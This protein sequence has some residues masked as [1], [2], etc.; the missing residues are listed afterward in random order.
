MQVWLR[1]KISRTQRS[2]KRGLPTGLKWRRHLRL[3]QALRANY[4]VSFVK[5]CRERCRKWINRV[6]DADWLASD[7]DDP[8]SN[9]KPGDKRKGVFDGSPGQIASS[10]RQKL[11]PAFKSLSTENEL[12]ALEEIDGKRKLDNTATPERQ[13]QTV[14][15]SAFSDTDNDQEDTIPRNASIP[16]L[17]EAKDS[18]GRGQVEETTGLPSDQVEPAPIERTAS[19][20]R[21][22]TFMHEIGMDPLDPEQATKIVPLPH[23][24]EARILTGYHHRSTCHKWTKDTYTLHNIGVP[25]RSQGT[26]APPSTREPVPYLKTGRHGLGGDFA[27][28]PDRATGKGHNYDPVDQKKYEEYMEFRALFHGKYPEY[29]KLDTGVSVDAKML[30]AWRRNEVWYQ[31]FRQKYTG[32]LGTQWVCGCQKILD[33][34]EGEGES[35]AE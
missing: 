10:K 20:G 24:N 18:P 9:S 25:I 16:T 14:E 21:L 26:F 15:A 12:L 7:F 17:A 19:S 28:D 22:L 13:Q 31:G 11:H 30:E 27:E 33:E 29:P 34:D 23:C 3:A 5:L 4:N 32:M 2:Q 6:P 8:A 35:E 1:G